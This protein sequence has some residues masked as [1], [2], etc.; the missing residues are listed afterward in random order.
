VPAKKQSTM[1][2]VKTASIFFALI[3]E[4]NQEAGF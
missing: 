3:K 2:W 1:L 4:T